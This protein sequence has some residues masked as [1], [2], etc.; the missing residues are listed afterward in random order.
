MGTI[1][2]VRSLIGMR[3]EVFFD[4]NAPLEEDKLREYLKES[5]KDVRG[6]LTLARLLNQKKKN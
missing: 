3:G 4:E 5:P 2:K 6:W 1:L